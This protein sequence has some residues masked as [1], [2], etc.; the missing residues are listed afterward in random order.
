MI[1][2]KRGHSAKWREPGEGLRSTHISWPRRAGGCLKTELKTG[3]LVVAQWLT[4]LTR[5]HEVEGS[6]PG[7]AQW[8]K[9]PAFQ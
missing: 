1:A 9:D 3:V 8:V 5:N 2:S 4:N 7:L 6:I